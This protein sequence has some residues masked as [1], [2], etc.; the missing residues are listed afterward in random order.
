MLP[1]YK[2]RAATL[3]AAKE[4]RQQFEQLIAQE[5]SQARSR[6]P[7]RHSWDSDEEQQPAD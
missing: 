7:Q 5:R 3:A 1:L 6:R 4:G 2:D